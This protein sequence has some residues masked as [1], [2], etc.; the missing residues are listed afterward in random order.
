MYIQRLQLGI[1]AM[2]AAVGGIDALIFTAGVGENS[3]EVRAA[4]CNR[5]GFLGIKLDEKRNSQ[6]PTDSEI[7][8]SDCAVRVLIIRAQEDWAIAEAC[9]RILKRA[10]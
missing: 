4:A 5:L 7:S 3:P 2:S 10:N 6:S 9:W 8:T 1:A